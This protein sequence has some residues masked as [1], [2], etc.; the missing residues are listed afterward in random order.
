MPPKPPSQRRALQR[1]EILEAVKSSENDRDAAVET[2]VFN[3]PASKGMDILGQNRPDPRCATTSLWRWPRAC[4]WAG[5]VPSPQRFRF[6]LL[7]HLSQNC[8]A[9]YRGVG[10]FQSFVQRRKAN[11][12]VQWMPYRTG[13]RESRFHCAENFSPVHR[14]GPAVNVWLKPCL[15]SHHG[16]WRIVVSMRDCYDHPSQQLGICQVYEWNVFHGPRTMSH[17]HCKLW[18]I[19]VSLRRFSHICGKYYIGSVIN[20]V[21]LVSIVD[22]DSSSRCSYSTILGLISRCRTVNSQ[23]WVCPLK[24]RKSTD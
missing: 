9:C 3:A 20:E 16:R 12:A 1:D 15:L 2:P 23:R 4:C 14:D 6:Q 5:G 18:G 19:F 8:T 24:E 7:H 22:Q 13:R 11:G 10:S 21:W 17:N